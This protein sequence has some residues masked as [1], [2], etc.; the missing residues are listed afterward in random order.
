MS[1]DEEVLGGTTEDVGKR[2]RK[3]LIIIIVVLFLLGGGSAL[4]FSGVLDS[5]TG[6][7]NSKKTEA[8]EEKSSKES[9]E[10]NKKEKGKSEE[11][12]K[13]KG[14]GGEE[15]DKGG[16]QATDSSG[17][18]YYDLPEFLVNLN[19]S[20]KGISFLKLKVTLE[21]PS[22]EALKQVQEMQ[23]R[24]VDMFNTYLR[25]LRASDLG[26]SAGIYRLREELLARINK[27]VHPQQVNNILIGEM[28]VQ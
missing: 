7:S 10:K 2:K 5:A 3:K 1:T 17:T 16:V 27:A 12:K 9:D 21:L 11:G 15:N 8:A 6:K 18:I 20:G 4:Y 25:E 22:D 24:I 23:P 14:K 13:A 26:G 19:T 28:I